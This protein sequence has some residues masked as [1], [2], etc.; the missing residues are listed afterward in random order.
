MALS[1]DYSDCRVLNLN[2]ADPQCGPFLATQYAIA[3]D[4][5]SQEENLYLLQRD[6]VWIEYATH[7][8]SPESERV[9]VEFDALADIVKLFARMPPQ[10]KI[11][12]AATVD[13]VKLTQFL[14]HVAAD[15]GMLAHIRGEV[16]AYKAA[17]LPA[18][19]LECENNTS[20][21]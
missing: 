21:S 19:H 20:T 1:N 3:P 18:S 10:P 2:P 14:Q 4:D 8:L 9:P 5:P 17:H 6:G 13:Q 15:G 7:V 16:A 12:R 11:I